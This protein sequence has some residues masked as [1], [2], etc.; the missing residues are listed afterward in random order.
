M[1]RGPASPKPGNVSRQTGY[2]V[3]VAGRLGPALRLAFPGM[4]A[5]D[6]PGH[7]VLV[8]PGEGA[9]LPALLALLHRRG[10]R[11]ARI[12]LRRQEP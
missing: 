2:E 8:L 10:I 3:R 6:E 1:R 12:H 7:S 9:S 5:V 4:S 11:V